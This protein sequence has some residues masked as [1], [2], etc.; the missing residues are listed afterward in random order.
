MASIK[1]TEGGNFGNYKEYNGGGS[2]KGGVWG[3][4]NGRV[5]WDERKKQGEVKEYEHRKDQPRT[6]DG[7]FT[8]NSVNG[9]ETKYDG[10]GETVNPLLTGGENGVYIKDVDKR[11]KAHNGVESQFKNKSGE[12][13]DRYKGKWQPKGGMKATKEGKKFTIQFAADNIWDL[14]KYAINPESGEFGES[15]RAQKAGLTKEGEQWKTKMGAP[16]K[17]GIEAKKEAKKTGQ[18]Q[19]VK[20]EDGAVARFKDPDGAMRM[21]KKFNLK[22]DGSQLKHTPAQIKQVRD[23]MIKSG[24]DMANITDEQIDAVA[25]DFIQ[26]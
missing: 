24:F 22:T 10:R 4:A 25:D 15:K 8:Y 18:E 23:M 20:T 7:K 1:D 13:F 9:K 5:G 19:F 17:A 2:P 12:V 14:A 6:D 3:G 26:F 16:G 11:G 21:A